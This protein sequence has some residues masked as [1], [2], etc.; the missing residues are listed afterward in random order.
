[1]ILVSGQF[2]VYEKNKSIRITL[3]S[4]CLQEALEYGTCIP[5]SELVVVFEFIQI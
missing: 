5:I 1:M 3:A 4:V 2:N